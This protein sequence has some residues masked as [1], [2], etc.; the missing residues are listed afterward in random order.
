LLDFFNTFS[1]DIIVCDAQSVIT[2]DGVRVAFFSDGGGTGD[3][4][5]E[6]ARPGCQVF[7][8]EA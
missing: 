5:T 4:V 8:W 7:G 3:T 1:F 2:S 6:P